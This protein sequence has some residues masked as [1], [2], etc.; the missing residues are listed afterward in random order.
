M[1]CLVLQGGLDGKFFSFK[2]NEL[3]SSCGYH[4]LAMNERNHLA[5]ETKIKEERLLASCEENL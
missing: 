5:H 4:S 3:I 2:T 1:R